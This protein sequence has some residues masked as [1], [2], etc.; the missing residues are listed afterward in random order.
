MTVEKS[1]RKANVSALL[2]GTTMQ[3][4]D[5]CMFSCV[6]QMAEVTECTAL[7]SCFTKNF[8]QSDEEAVHAGEFGA[9]LNM[10]SQCRG[11]EPRPEPPPMLT[12]TFKCGLKKG[13]TAML[14]SFQSPGIAPEVN[15][16]ITQAR[17]HAKRDPPWL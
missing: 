1:D 5:I 15:L 2:C 16:R 9:P 6:L 11:F 3:V 7:R 17:K 10:F 8:A 4:L 14:S 13:S 12:D